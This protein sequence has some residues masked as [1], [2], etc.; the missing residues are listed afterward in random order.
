M[1]YTLQPAANAM[2]I[3]EQQYATAEEIRFTAFTSCIGIIGRQGPNLTGVHLVMRA[4]DD[5]PFDTPAVLAVLARL[6]AHF[7]TVWIIGCTDLWENPQ[8]NVLAAFGQLVAGI[9]SDEAVKR[10]PLAP[11]T[12][13]AR[14]DEDGALALT[15]P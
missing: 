15:Y 9:R 1:P 5:S 6:T 13:G 8:N 14:I 10:F 12:Y 4:S 11:S 7:E 2:A 3:A